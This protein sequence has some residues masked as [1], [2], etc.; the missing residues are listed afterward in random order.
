MRMG[1]NNENEN[2]WLWKDEV[3]TLVFWNPED[4]LKSLIKRDILIG[5]MAGQDLRNQMIAIWRGE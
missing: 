1:K 5:Q 3:W 2:G 4:V